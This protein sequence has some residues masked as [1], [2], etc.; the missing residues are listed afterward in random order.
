MHFGKWILNSHQKGAVDFYLRKGKK[1]ILSGDWNSGKTVTSLA[2]MQF[3]KS[4][5]VLILC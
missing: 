5:K 1:M 4:R 2:C 3:G